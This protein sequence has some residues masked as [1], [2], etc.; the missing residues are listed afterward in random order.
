MIL[1]TYHARLRR[2][3]ESRFNSAQMNILKIADHLSER[4]INIFERDK[5]QQTIKLWSVDI[6]DRIG[7][8]GYRSVTCADETYWYFKLCWYHREATLSLFPVPL[9]RMAIGQQWTCTRRWKR[10]T[11]RKTFCSTSAQTQPRCNDSTTVES[12]DPAK[13]CQSSDTSWLLSCDI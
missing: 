10:I 7:L 11:F 13:K 12:H 8:I 9:R 1:C 2:S 6:R 3:V 4:L 5:V